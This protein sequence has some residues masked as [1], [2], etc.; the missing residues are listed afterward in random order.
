MIMK[1]FSR[2][3]VKKITNYSILLERNFW[4]FRILE[5]VDYSIGEIE[6]RECG[7]NGGNW[8]MKNGEFQETAGTSRSMAAL[9]RW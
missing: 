9:P 1:S 5:N 2:L 4:K 6:K 3:I 8:R 7:L